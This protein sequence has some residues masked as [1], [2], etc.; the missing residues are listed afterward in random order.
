M[1]EP[2]ICRELRIRLNTI[3]HE[4]AASGDETLRHNAKMLYWGATM[5]ARGLVN[6][7]QLSDDALMF[8]CGKPA[9]HP[10]LP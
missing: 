7:E 2:E 4:A 1:N 5:Y 9:R 3:A 8:A 10:E 6:E